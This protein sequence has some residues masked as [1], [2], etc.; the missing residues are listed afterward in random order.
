MRFKLYTRSYRLI[1]DINAGNV[2]AGTSICVISK[3]F[4]DD[5]ASGIYYAVL[6]D[7]KTGERTKPVLIT[8]LK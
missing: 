7:E 2:P 3:K 1:R 8:I 4:L 6:Q 5:T